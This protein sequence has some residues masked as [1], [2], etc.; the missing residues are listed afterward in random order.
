MAFNLKD[1]KEKAVYEEAVEG[2]NAQYNIVV[3]RS[4]VGTLQKVYESLEK[5]TNDDEVV[6]Q[7]CEV[8]SD[9]PKELFSDM[10]AMDDGFLTFFEIMVQIMKSLETE[11]N[12][13]TIAD[14]SNPTIRQAKR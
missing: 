4:V 1:I 8:I 6:K 10:V 7:I 11:L 12:L 13:Q 3:K 14:F 2:L 9:N 5:S